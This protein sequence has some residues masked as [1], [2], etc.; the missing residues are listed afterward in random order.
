VIERGQSRVS[1]LDHLG[2]CHLARLFARLAVRWRGSGRAGTCNLVKSSLDR[3]RAAAE[4]SVRCNMAFVRTILAILMALSVAMLPAAGAAGFKL[5]SQDA[6]EISASEPMHDCC[7]P[8][9]NP[10]G[11]VM[12]DCGSMAT[13]A[14]KCFNYSSDVSSLLVYPFTLADMTPLFESIGFH[15]Q[16]GSPPFR[17]PRA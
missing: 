16:T 11:K 13:C 17:P 10:C 3:Q 5:K 12:D 6:T 2:L 1:D 4:Y 15:S 8:R 7:P 14:V 9:T